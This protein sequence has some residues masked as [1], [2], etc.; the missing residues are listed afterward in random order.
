MLEFHRE[1]I[2]IKSAQN[3]NSLWKSW[4]LIKG[5]TGNNKNCIL[6]CYSIQIVKKL[7]DHELPS[8]EVDCHSL[9]SHKKHLSP[10]EYTGIFMTMVTVLEFQNI[11]K[12]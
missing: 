3:S 5:K 11:I 1:L 4:D 10:T 2:I 6:R 9:K 8:A 7:E 12:N